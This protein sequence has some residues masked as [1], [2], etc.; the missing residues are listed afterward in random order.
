[1][2]VSYK[3]D[4]FG[5]ELKKIRKSL[6]FNQS[7]IQKLTGISVDTLRR[8]ENGHV[9]PQYSTLEVLSITYRQD[10]LELL[11]SCRSSKLLMDFFNKLDSVISNYKE[12]EIVELQKEFKDALSSNKILVLNPLEIKQFE[13][14]LEAIRLSNSRLSSDIKASELKFFEAIKLTLPSFNIKQHKKYRYSYLEFRILLLLS[15]SIAEDNKFKLSN[16]IL[17]FILEKL[18]NDT[19]QTKYSRLLIIKVYSNIAYNYHMLAQ[20][21]K[22]IEISNEGINY[23]LAEEILHGLHSLYYR[24]GIS[25]YRLEHEDYL[26]SL[27]YAVFMLKITKQWELLDLVLRVTKDKYNINI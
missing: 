26:D 9:I 2:F 27:K 6:G 16:N 19:N 10:L 3:L 13:L 4:E 18:K 11:K 23:C 24:Q 22:V 15:L 5:N 1:M 25:K 17:Y 14:L 8:I 7:Y 12:D 21:D 20:H